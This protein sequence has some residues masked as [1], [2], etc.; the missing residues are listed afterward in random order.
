MFGYALHAE[1]RIAGA[2][3]M[4]PQGT[5]PNGVRRSG[6]PVATSDVVQ[7]DLYRRKPEALDG[8]QTKGNPRRL[9]ILRHKSG[10]HQHPT[11]H[12]QWSYE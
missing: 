4:E 7:L 12:L 11:I 8:R 6:Q 2:M 9:Q 10:Y 1:L 3:A 5:T